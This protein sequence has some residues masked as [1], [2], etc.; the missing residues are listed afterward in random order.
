[1]KALTS[2]TQYAIIYGYNCGQSGYTIAEHLGCS[3]TA[4][5]K[6]LKHYRETGSF[7]PVKR[8]GRLL[9]FDSPVRMI[10]QL[11]DKICNIADFGVELRLVIRN[12]AIHL[13]GFGTSLPN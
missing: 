4:I 7:T 5:Y 12:S 6:I 13:I 10:P 1:M 2:K 3:K 9:L 8:P 11:V